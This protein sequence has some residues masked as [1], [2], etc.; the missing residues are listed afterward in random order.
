MFQFTENQV[1]IL[2]DIVH[3]KKI[4]LLIKFVLEAALVLFVKSDNTTRCETSKSLCPRKCTCN[5][6]S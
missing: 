3:V 4:Y 2:H 1:S 5:V 6:Q